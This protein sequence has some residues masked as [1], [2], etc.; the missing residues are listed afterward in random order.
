MAAHSQRAE[1]VGIDR[2]TARR[3][4]NGGS[5]DPKEQAL[6]AL[7]TKLIKDRGHHTG[8]VIDTAREVGATDGEMVEVVSLVAYHT[9][10]NSLASMAG[11]EVDSKEF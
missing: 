9:F 10:L 3:Y 7:A 6:L 8:F 1:A 2:E 4:R 5:L 11:P